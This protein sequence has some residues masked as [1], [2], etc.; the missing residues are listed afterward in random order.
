MKR[1]LL[2]GAVVLGLGALALSCNR[3]KQQLGAARNDDCRKVVP[4]APSAMEVPL[5][6]DFTRAA[7]KLIGPDN[8][9]KQLARIEREL[10]ELADADAMGDE[11]GSADTASAAQR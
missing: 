8:Y 2:V 9:N 1:L 3:E 10:A 4:Y 7:E 6:D 5:P 11:S